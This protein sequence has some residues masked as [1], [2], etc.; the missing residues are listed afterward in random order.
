MLVQPFARRSYLRWPRTCVS[1]KPLYNFTTSSFGKATRSVALGLSFE[2]HDDSIIAAKKSFYSCLIFRKI[3]NPFIARLFT[4]IASNDP[5]PV[6]TKSFFVFVDECCYC[7]SRSL[8][9]SATRLSTCIAMLERLRKSLVRILWRLLYLRKT[10]AAFIGT[11]SDVMWRTLSC[12]R[13]MGFHALCHPCLGPEYVHRNA[14]TVL[15]LRHCKGCIGHTLVT[16][17]LSFLFSFIFLEFN[18]VRS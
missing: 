12:A 1:A 5:H 9:W 17:A 7:T 11:H 18:F 8:F 15:S 6:A 3:A 2:K 4:G 13:E 14:S 10:L 16:R